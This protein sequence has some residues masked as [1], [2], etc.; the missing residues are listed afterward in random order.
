MSA[1]F[2]MTAVIFY[3]YECRSSC[4]VVNMSAVTVAGM[5]SPSYECC[6]GWKYTCRCY[7]RYEFC[8]DCSYDLL[9]WLLIWCS[10]ENCAICSSII[11]IFMVDVVVVILF[12]YG[13]YYCS[14]QSLLLLLWLV[15]AVLT[16][17]SLYCTHH[18]ILWRQAD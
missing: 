8:N 18:N 2:V 13:R 10:N 4:I 7:R 12:C 16:Q 9:L 5:I 1:T 3:C 14:I 6:Y 15:L 11:S 17:F